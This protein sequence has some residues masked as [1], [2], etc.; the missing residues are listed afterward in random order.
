MFFPSRFFAARRNR[1]S[2]F[3]SSRR[4]YKP[5]LEVLEDRHL[6]ATLTVFTTADSG[7]GSLRQAILDANALPGLDMIQFSLEVPPFTIS[8]LS[9]LPAITDPVIIDGT[10]QPGFT[11]AP[12]IELDGSNAGP[13]DGL[14]ITA[15]GS[16][17]RGL[18]IDGFQGNGISLLFNGGNDIEGDYLGTNGK[19]PA[20][21]GNTGDGIFISNASNNTIGGTGQGTGNVISGNGG[22]GVAIVASTT[23]P[24][25]L[26]PPGDGTAIGPAA[27]QASGNLI[28]G[29]FIGTN[30]TGTVA[31][32]NASDGVTID[33]APGNILGGSVTGAGNVISANGGDGVR[34][35]GTNAAGNLLQ[36]NL[37][38]TDASGTRA[39]GNAV[40]GIGIAD[41]SNNTIGGSAGNTIAFNGGNGVTVVS[42]TGN[43]ILSNSIFA[44]N[45][46]GIDLG[47]EG[48]T[49]NDPND[50]DTGAN[51][52]QNFPVIVSVTPLAESVQIKALLNSSPS[53]TFV[54]QFFGNAAADP[55]GFGQ[56]K[57]FIGSTV[58]TTDANGNAVF[59][60][61]VAPGLANFI[62]ATATDPA[63]NTS[64]FSGLN[65]LSAA[66]L[67]ACAVESRSANVALATFTDASGPEPAANYSATIDWNDGTPASAG[68][69]TLSG[70][71]FTV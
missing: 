11:G 40:D 69:V 18:I 2:T 6:L 29:N 60:A 26:R 42:G 63:D 12:I 17:V 23:S 28:Q 46:L 58:V 9:P 62:T 61:N 1:S 45:G 38:G 65:F 7:Q 43:G 30:L 52:L 3:Q 25:L 57:T 20:G 68:V 27:S 33:S 37:I 47:G 21:L 36:G 15:G 67:T 44:N 56:G 49:L 22:S 54:I 14:A 66:G 13:A 34:I 71:T 53:T 4:S 8:P 51:N 59:T 32:G 39:L 64:E 10:T 5:S 31:L 55:S 35:S 70:T 48:V 24:G 19:S 41:S 50:L 16:T